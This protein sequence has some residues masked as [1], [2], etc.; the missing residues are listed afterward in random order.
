MTSSD[1]SERSAAI[2]GLQQ[3][4]SRRGHL[5]LPYIIPKLLKKPITISNAQA[6]G[7]V[8]FATRSSIHHQVCKKKYIYL[9][10]KMMCCN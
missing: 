8:A 9:K 3:M 10:K 5:I 2:Q 4:L 7:A 6:I 1:E